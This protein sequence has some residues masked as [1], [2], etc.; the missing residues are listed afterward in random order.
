MRAILAAIRD[1]FSVKF[2]TRTSLELEVVAL[3]YQLK[4]LKRRKAARKYYRKISKPDRIFLV[5]LYSLFP[6]LLQYVHIVRPVTIVH[7][8]RQ[9][10][11]LYW[12]W[13]S[14]AKVGPKLKME[15]YELVLRMHR[16][17]PIWGAGRI[18]GELKKL[19]YCLSAQTVL[20]YLN[21]F[22]RKPLP[23]S[24]TWRTFLRNHI[25]ETV[26]AD[27]FVVITATYKFLYVFVILGLHRR[28]ILHFEITEHPNQLWISNQISKTF[29]SEPR[30]R[31]LLRDRDACYGGTFNKRLKRMGIQN[32]IAAPHSPWHNNYIE[33][34]IGKIRNECLNHVIV[35]NERHLRRLLSE[36]V[37]YYNTVRTHE[38]LDGDCP[39]SRQVQPVYDGRKII[40]I[41]HVGG[42]HHKYE[43]HRTAA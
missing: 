1:L 41:P 25:K 39:N 35:F 11:R 14:R 24:P 33:S 18:H 37:N 3:R 26:C 30:P 31:F 20:R 16:D 15:V 21:S 28:K 5:W 7:W 17:N 23:P 42:L 9:G 10:F 4:I 12:R 40:A 19:G 13:K 2:R 36:Y 34:L 8:H 6:C 32:I 27:L 43:R 29:E 38:A 22:R